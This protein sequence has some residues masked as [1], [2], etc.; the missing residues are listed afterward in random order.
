MNHYRGGGDVAVFAACTGVRIG[1]VSGC[2][3]RRHQLRLTAM[4]GFGAKLRRLLAA[5]RAK[6]ARA[7]ELVRSAHRRDPRHGATTRRECRRQPGSRLPAGP[8]GGQIATAVLCRHGL[9][10]TGLTWI[11]VSRQEFGR[12]PAAVLHAVAQLAKSGSNLLRL[13]SRASRGG[14][15]RGGG[16]RRRP[17]PLPRRAEAT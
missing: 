6:E 7:N 16:P 14:T 4:V 10:H 5:S 8:R 15:L 1:E 11:L 3:V 17:V 13:L 2:R 9:R 12:D